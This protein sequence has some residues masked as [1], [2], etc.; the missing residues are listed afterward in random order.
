MNLYI[1]VYD[2]NLIKIRIRTKAGIQVVLEKLQKASTHLYSKIFNFSI[3]FCNDSGFHSS[4]SNLV[5]MI[6]QFW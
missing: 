4:F 3:E 6:G 2:M 1:N 5:T